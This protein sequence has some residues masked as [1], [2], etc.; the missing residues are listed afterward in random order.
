MYTETPARHERNYPRPG[1]YL[2]AD[3]SH[4]LRDPFSTGVPIFIGRCRTAYDKAVNKLQ[5]I[6]LWSHFAAYVGEPYQDCILG[7]AVRGFFQNGGSNCYVFVV[8]DLNADTVQRALDRAAELSTI[9]LVCIPDLGE[10]R[11][12]AIALQ[13]MVV[14]HCEDTGDRFA[15]LDSWRDDEPKQVAEVWSNIDGANGALYYPWLHVRNFEEKGIGETRVLIPPCGHVAGVYSRT[16]QNRG[17]HKAPANEVLEGV[18]SLER[19]VN[20]VAHEVTTPS[21]INCIRSFAGR[22]IRIWGARTLSGNDMWTFVNVRRMFLTMIRWLEWHM[23]SVVFEP[24]DPRLWS[25]IES[26][27]HQYLLGLY[28]DGALQGRSSTDS[29]YVRCNA[30]TNPREVTESGRVIAEIGLAAMIPFE[31]VVVRL[32]YGASGVSISGPIRPEQNS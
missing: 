13:Q 11:A 26:D 21:R 5:R 16:D 23:K 32:I 22:G 27:L 24:N 10:S 29:Y 25:R 15:I 18:V 8:S 12:P 20:H 6:T 3:Y 4:P 9:D 2:Q 7:Y 31:F 1:V 28:R 17:V 30:T 19:Q 14:A